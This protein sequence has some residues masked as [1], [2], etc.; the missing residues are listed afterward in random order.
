MS[1]FTGSALVDPFCSSEDR[2]ERSP[3][4]TQPLSPTPETLLF[5]GPGGV[6]AQAL[7][8]PESICCQHPMG[9]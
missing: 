8:R 2:G 1:A 6:C 9:E 3:W 7:G 5:Q 4:V